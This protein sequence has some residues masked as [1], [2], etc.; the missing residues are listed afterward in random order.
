MTGPE[1]S[2][3]NTRPISVAELLAKNG[4]IGAPPAGGRRRRRRGDSDAVTVAELTGEIPIVSGH[5]TDENETT[6]TIPAVTDEP[7]STNGVGSH[8][9]EVDLEEAEPKAE[10]AQDDYEDVDDHYAEAV[11]DYSAHIERRDTDDDPVDFFAPP[12][13]RPQYTPAQRRFG[14]VGAE[15][16]SPDPVDEDDLELADEP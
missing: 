13:R 11:A 2:H 8:A 5:D 6:R 7:V 1:D 10:P 9:D 3:S 4:T 15:Q 16:M 14:A 12:P